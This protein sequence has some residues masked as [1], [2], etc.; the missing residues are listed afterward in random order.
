LVSGTIPELAVEVHEDPVMMVALVGDALSE[1][2]PLIHIIKEMRA[3]GGRILS[4]KG[5]IESLILH[6][7]GSSTEILG[8][9]HDLVKETEGVKAVSAVEGK[10]LISVRGRRLDNTAKATGEVH[11]AL[12]RKGIKIHGLITSQSSAKVLVDWERRWEASEIIGEELRR[13]RNG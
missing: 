6:V 3:P 2:E 4:M 1:P 12:L 5:D 9:M 8:G 7:T 11:D 13:P 10:A